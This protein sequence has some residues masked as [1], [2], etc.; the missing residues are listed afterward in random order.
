MSDNNQELLQEMERAIGQLEQSKMKT[1]DIKAIL[2]F[3]Y[4][5]SALN[6]LLLSEIDALKKTSCKSKAKAKTKSKAKASTKPVDIN[7]NDTELDG[8]EEL[9]LED[10]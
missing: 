7:N 10:L 4:E 9:N 3:L 2:R 1:V 8:S 6:I 5:Q